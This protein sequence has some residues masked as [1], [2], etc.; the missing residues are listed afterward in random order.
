MHGEPSKIIKQ[1]SVAISLDKNIISY[2]K[3]Q[4]TL[5]SIIINNKQIMN[6]R[7]VPHILYKHS[8]PLWP[9]PLASEDPET[10]N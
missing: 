5:L 3:V 8:A 4:H 9:L 1:T 10:P 2:S 6:E 7:K